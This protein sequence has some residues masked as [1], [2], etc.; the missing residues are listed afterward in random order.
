MRDVTKEMIEIFKINKLGYDMAGYTFKNKKDLSFHHLLVAKRNCKQQ[1]LGEGYYFWNGA[2]LVQ[3]TSHDYLHTIERI[4]PDMFYVITSELLDENI[5]REIK[6][7]SLKR[8]R[9][10]LLTFEREHC[11]ERTHKGSP[12]IK[13]SFVRDRIK[14]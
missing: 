1:G 9:D 14:L 12:I 5:A 7:E 2:I 11:S 10:V 3:A 4:D 8:I 6:I 13:E